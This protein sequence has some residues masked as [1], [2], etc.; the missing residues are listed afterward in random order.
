MKGENAWFSLQHLSGMG[1]QYTDPFPNTETSAIG[2]A[3]ANI[4][5]PPRRC[6]RAWRRWTRKRGSAYGSESLQLSWPSQHRHHRIAPSNVSDL[7]GVSAALRHMVPICQARRARR[8]QRTA[9]TTLLPARLRAIKPL[10][11]LFE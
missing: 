5:S 3:L 2:R 7:P 9:D 4:G 11:K 1:S 6:A 8:L 10:L